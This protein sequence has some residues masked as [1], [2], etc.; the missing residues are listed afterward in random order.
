[1]VL[2]RLIQ[3]YHCCVSVCVCVC[4]CVCKSI[5]E[6]YYSFASVCVCVCVCE[7]LLE[8]KTTVPLYVWMV[9]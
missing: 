5:L 4:V 9:T 1:M 8:D 7:L 3:L 6:D 2:R